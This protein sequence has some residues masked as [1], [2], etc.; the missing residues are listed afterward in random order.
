MTEKTL[1]DAL[2][3]D[4]DLYTERLLPHP[5]EHV[6]GAFTDPVKLERWWGPHGFTN[7]SKRCEPMPGGEW[8]VT[9]VGPDGSEHANLYRFIEMVEPAQVVVDHVSGHWFRLTVELHE[10]SG[11]TRVTWRQTF[12]SREE[13][14]QVA[15]YC[16]PGNEG[17][18]DRLGEEL[19]RATG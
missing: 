5:R 19:A 1:Q 3:G 10:A 9:L 14:D 15:A 6:Y 7:R 4:T 12:A 17:N 16:V 8:D 11:G 18:L 2:R 13:R